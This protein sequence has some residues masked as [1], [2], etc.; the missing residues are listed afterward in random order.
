MA[1]AVAAFSPRGLSEFPFR[2]RALRLYLQAGTYETPYL[3]GARSTCNLAGA[4][5]TVCRLDITDTGHAPLIWQA[6]W[7]KALVE[8]FPSHA[9]KR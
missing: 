4:S 3:K 2:N 5:N 9:G 1:G 7:A 6:E 8:A